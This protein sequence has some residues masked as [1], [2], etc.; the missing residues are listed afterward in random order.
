MKEEK[1]HECTCEDC[2]CTEDS[3]CSEDCDCNET[4]DCGCQDGKCTCDGECKCECKKEK[5]DKKKEKNKYKEEIEKLK[6]ENKK[7]EEEVVIARADLINYRKRKDEEVARM[8][9]FCNEDLMID[10]LPIIDNLERAL[11]VEGDSK[12]KEGVNMIYQILK[13]TLEKYGLKEIEA[14]DKEFDASIHQ[15]VVKDNDKT[16]QSNVIT[17]VMQKGYTLKNKVIR[18]AMVK[19]NE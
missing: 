14:L 18:P 7:K 17:E 1:K 2:N 19:V 5:K 6:L 16:K 15:A 12:L 10:L 13:S 9:L 8:L 11:V 3:K 4:C